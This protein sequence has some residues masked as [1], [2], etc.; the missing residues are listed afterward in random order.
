MPYRYAAFSAGGAAWRNR[1]EVAY[2]EEGEGDGVLE[3]VA[4]GFPPLAEEGL[5]WGRFVLV[6]VLLSAYIRLRS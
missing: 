6:I 5:L 3:G 1:I 2:R 4:H